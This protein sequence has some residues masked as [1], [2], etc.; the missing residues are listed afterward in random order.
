MIYKIQLVFQ[1]DNSTFYVFIHDFELT[2]FELKVLLGSNDKIGRVVCSV[3]QFFKPHSH[4]RKYN[5][6]YILIHNE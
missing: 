4:G 1:F 5:K 3:I 6:L 2:M